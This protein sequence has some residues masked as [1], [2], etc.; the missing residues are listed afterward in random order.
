MELYDITIYLNSPNETEAEEGIIRKSQLIT[1][2]AASTPKTTIIHNKTH[3]ER[4]PVAP[5]E[6]KTSSSRT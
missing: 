5:P 6:E 1:L 3:R 4:Q 2:I